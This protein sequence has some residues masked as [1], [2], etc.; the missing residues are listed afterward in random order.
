MDIPSVGTVRPVQYSTRP[1]Y[2]FFKM[3]TQYA[4]M[5]TRKF[6]NMPKT[7]L[8]KKSRPF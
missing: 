8:Y 4:N 2:R 3:S 1:A 5:D 7:N 6:Y